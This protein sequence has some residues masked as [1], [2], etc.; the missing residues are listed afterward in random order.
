MNTGKGFEFLQDLGLYGKGLLLVKDPIQVERYN[1]CLIEIGV[2][3]TQLK[4]FSIDGIGYSPEI[5]L[6]K[7]NKDYLSHEGIS[8]PYAILL[9]PEQEGLPIYRPYYSFYRNLMD[10]MFRTFRGQITDITLHTAIYI[11]FDEG[12]TK[13]SSAHELLFIEGLV[14]K[15]HVIGPIINAAKRQR[16][17]VTLLSQEDN[18]SDNELIEE[19][20]QN[21]SEHGKMTYQRIQLTEFPFMDMRSFYTGAFGGAYVFR[22]IDS[23][24][25]III[26]VDTANANRMEN[27]HVEYRFG[28]VDLYDRL[29]EHGIIELRPNY[30]TKGAS[31]EKLERLAECLFVDAV[32]K[33][34]N[35]TDILK[36]TESQRKQRAIKL[37]EQ[38][39]LSPVYD[40]LMNLTQLAQLKRK[41]EISNVSP[42]LQK[43][44]MH[45]HKGV[46]D[47]SRIVVHR[48]LAHLLP[49]D[50]LELYTYARDTFFEI[51]VTWPQNKQAWAAA[52]LKKHYTPRSVEKKQIHSH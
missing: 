27:G 24:K 3:P 23:D 45:P 26:H 41:K 28:D 49:I 18:W 35:T 29:Y 13:I 16:E 9:S 14:L 50:V 39:T 8:N 21:L 42:A 33:T 51:Y 2:E 10:E 6:E 47:S 22:D 12:H 38:G 44:L 46:K 7:D 36:I 15:F 19:L 4:E 43:I 48:L 40:E 30:Y 17:L 20:K 31:V 5:A 11:D 37:I 25:Q 32:T 1:Q 34:D 52:Y